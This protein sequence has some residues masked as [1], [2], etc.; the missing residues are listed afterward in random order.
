MTVVASEEELSAAEAYE[1][2]HVPALFAQWAPKMVAAAR[3]QPGHRVLD[4][5]CGTGALARQILP[6]VGEHGFVHG[7]DASAGMLAIADRLAP[8]IEW[9]NGAAESLPYTD[10]LFDAAVCQFGFMFFE[11]R[12]T[13]LQE[14]L[15]VLAPGSWLSISVWD[16]LDNSEAYRETVELLRDL[17]GED[18]A[19]A[20]CAPFNLGDQEALS[21]LF[22]NAGVDS[23][24]IETHTGKARFPSVR[25]MV[26]AELRGWLPL[27]G[28][29]L[30]ED[31]I[32]AILT[33]SEQ[34]LASYVQSDG[35]VEFEAP[36]HIACV[37]HSS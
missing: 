32:S 26:E 20:L 13:A 19:N 27:M 30:K 36:A 14:M 37:E 25:T 18:A 23:A 24:S 3:I 4:V 16:S 11:D 2:L 15:R 9:Q 1:S 31:L 12:V 6:I 10:G 29:N 22:R 7:L 34:V 8:S 21:R 35:T 17:A 33:E 28:V 5:A